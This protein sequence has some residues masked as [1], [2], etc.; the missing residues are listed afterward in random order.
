M[1]SYNLEN[2]MIILGE[3]INSKEHLNRLL[4]VGVLPEDFYR[5]NHKI[6][7]QGLIDTLYRHNSINMFLVSDTLEGKIKYTEISQLLKSCIG[8]SDIEPHINLLLGTSINRQYEELAKKILD[9]NIKDKG[10]YLKKEMQRIEDL[11]AR[12]NNLSTITTLDKVK[13]TDIYNAAKIKTGFKDIDKKI[14]G[15]LKG[16]LV[17]I[18]GYNG[19]GKSTLIN[20]MCIAE[21]IAQGHKVFAY[22]PELTNSNLK[23]WLY[24]TIAEQEHFTR[25]I[26]C[27]GEEYKVVGDIGNRLIDDW[28][29][30]KLYIYSDDTITSK[31]SQLLSDMEK[32][33]KL[34]GVEVF[35]I[36]N[37]MKIDL[38]ESYKNELVAQKIFVNKLK[39]FARKYNA[40]IHLV[41]HPRKPQD[42][43]RKITKFDIAGS[44]DITNLAD[45]VLSIT[46]VTEEDRKENSELKDCIIKVMKDRPKGTSEFYINLSFDM[47]RR[48]FYSSNGELTRNY[49]YAPNNRVIQV[50]LN[51][52][53]F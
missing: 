34:Q 39:E 45:Y 49:G 42:G 10:E 33:V 2:E 8:L 38:E 17:I 5:S 11:K 41:A 26:N 13:F 53:V 9:D 12:I 50:E 23:S 28:I 3:C 37:L 47:D 48:R 31:E 30:D 27:C 51:K 24:P 46:R 29:K 43:K 32:M 19:N 21:S 16:S 35:I 25:K 36:D 52:D 20:Q 22:S 40:V 6:I 18:T 15:I 7:Y 1:Y 4:S 44:G 14:L